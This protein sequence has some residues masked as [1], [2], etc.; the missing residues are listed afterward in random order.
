[1]T[2]QEDVA[3]CGLLIDP[4][5]KL[6]IFFTFNGKLIGDFGDGIG[7]IYKNFSINFNKIFTHFIGRQ[8]PIS[9][10]VDRLYPAIEMLYMMSSEANF[11]DDPAKPF[12]FDVK[13]FPGL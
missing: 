7:F 11:G 10:S 1:L 5:D 9:T 13:N 8:I 12:K 2:G 4:N 6:A 3:G